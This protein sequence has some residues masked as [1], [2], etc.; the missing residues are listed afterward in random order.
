MP[1]TDPIADLLNRIR[2]AHKAKH[3]RVD[4]PFSK[5]KSEI[6][7]VLMDCNFI[8]DFVHVDEGPQGYLRLYLKYTAQ[9]KPVIQGIRRISSPGLRRYVNK[10]EIPRVLNGL[11]V[12]ILTT[13]RGVMT[14]N[15]ARKQGLGGEV[16]AEIW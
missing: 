11:G 2:N 12:S 10:D 14:G 3:P 4:I 13:S 6:A 1:T 8:H 9:G 15:Q 5:V 7:R 16:L